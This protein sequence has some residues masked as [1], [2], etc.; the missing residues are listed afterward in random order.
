MR[1]ISMLL[2]L[3]VMSAV[4]SAQDTLVSRVNE[5]STDGDDFGTTLDLAWKGGTDTGTVFLTSFDNNNPS[6]GTQILKAQIIVSG[7]GPGVKVRWSAHSVIS[8]IP[9]KVG[10]L[11][12]FHSIVRMGVSAGQGR[13]NNDIGEFNRFPPQG[14]EITPI[15][16]VNSPQWDSHPFVASTGSII[17]FTSRRPGGHGGADI[18]YSLFDKVNTRWGEPVNA[19]PAINSPHDEVS[20]M[21]APDHQ[22]LYFSSNRPCGIGGFDVYA[23]QTDVNVLGLSRNELLSGNCRWK[24]AFPVP[25]INTRYDELFYTAVDSALGLFSS[26]RPRDPQDVTCDMD[27]YVVTPNPLPPGPYVYRRFRMVSCVD[28]TPVVCPIQVSNSNLSV[29]PATI[30]PDAD[31]T[32][33]IQFPRDGLYYLDPTCLNFF[34][35]EK[36]VDRHS[37]PSGEIETLTMT[38]VNALCGGP[39]LIPILFGV[40]SAVVKP[41][42]FEPLR[43]T[44]QKIQEFFALAERSGNRTAHVILHGHTDCNNTPSYNDRLALDRAN[45]VFAFIMQFIDS[46]YQRRISVVTHGERDLKYRTGDR[47]CEDAVPFQPV[48][49]LTFPE[50]E[51][52]HEA[53]RRVVMELVP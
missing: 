17:F 33:S 45:A 22:T 51:D 28:G 41:E 35:I 46:R 13:G 47:S 9:A 42:F 43:R 23:V 29:Q 10:G 38:P 52:R 53:N 15:E 21:M 31:G 26:N 11:A 12:K 18:W 27:I 25:R 39:D 20:P 3:A 2:L 19:G 49:P 5:L 48:E 4:A 16:A 34:G 24:I 44:A 8:V 1:C 32:F 36:V 6:R 37:T 14:L 40:D 7:S 50:I 30:H